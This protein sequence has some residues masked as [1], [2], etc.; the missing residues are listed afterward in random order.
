MTLKIHLI[1]MPFYV[2][3]TKYLL[4]NVYIVNNIVWSS[5]TPQQTSAELGKILNK[6]GPILKFIIQGPAEELD[7]LKMI[8]TYCGG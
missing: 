7:G 6:D 2:F 8:T 4:N 5:L 1:S 3:S